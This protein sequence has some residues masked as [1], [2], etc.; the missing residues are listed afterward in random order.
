[1]VPVQNSDNSSFASNQ[2]FPLADN[3]DNI[4]K[5]KRMWRAQWPEFSWLTVPNDNTSR[6][7]QMFAPDI[8][9]VGYGDPD[10]QKNNRCPVWSVMCPQ[11]GIWIEAIEG[12]L[13]VEV[14][15]TS[16]GGW[17][18]EN[19]MTIDAQITIQPKIW[20]SPDTMQNNI[21]VRL[22]W[23]LFKDINIPFPSS[24]ANAIKLN[25]YGVDKQDHP[26]KSNVL[27]I[28]NGLDPNYPVPPFAQHKDPD[29]YI[30]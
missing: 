29:I 26:V 27:N 21:L 3:M 16:S 30:T 5:I 20:F 24:K 14:T 17:V 2:R 4:G 13:N 12:T 22:L 28:I 6:C 7:Y 11:Q 23:Q 8:S 19:P 18:I 9:R 1:M 25:A 15:V 10:P